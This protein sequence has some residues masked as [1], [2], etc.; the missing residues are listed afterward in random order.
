MGLE[1]DI[2]MPAWLKTAWLF[3]KRA[4]GNPHDNALAESLIKTLNFEAV[5]LMAYETM[6]SAL[7][8]RGSSTPTRLAD[9]T[10]L[11][12]L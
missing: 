4:R 7:T 5:Y 1:V 12:A 3:H 9:C 6:R 10:R 11:W 2:R 8:S